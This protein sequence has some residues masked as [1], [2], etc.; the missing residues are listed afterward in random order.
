MKIA[1]FDLYKSFDCH[2]ISTTDFF[3]QVSIKLC[4]KVKDHGS[5]IFCL[6]NGYNNASS[7]MKCN[8]WES[9]EG[10]ATLSVCGERI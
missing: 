9:R 1:F 6:M 5:K 3:V 8:T 7:T 4:V 2:N 10:D